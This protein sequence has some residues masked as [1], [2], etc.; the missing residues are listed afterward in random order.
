MQVEKINIDKMTIH[1]TVYKFIYH[2]IP[3]YS[4]LHSKKK[5]SFDSVLYF[6]QTFK[7]L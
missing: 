6:V 5:S 3:N 2:I 1:F 7:I 4:F